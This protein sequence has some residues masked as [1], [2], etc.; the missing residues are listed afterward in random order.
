MNKYI[1]IVGILFGITLAG[2]QD[3]LEMNGADTQRD[4]DQGLPITFTTE[5]L[6]IEISG[7]TLTRAT[8]EDKYK[9]EFIEAYEEE[10]G[11]G[12]TVTKGD[13]LH[14]SATFTLL[15]ED[16]Q[17]ADINA[18]TT[19]LYDCMKLQNGEWTSMGGGLTWPWNAEK[20]TFTVYYINGSDGLL[21]ENDPSEDFELSN[22]TYDTDPLMAVA[23]DVPYGYAVPLKFNHLC[24][25]LSITDV[26]DRGSE[27]WAKITRADGTRMANQFSLTRNEND[28]LTF[29][30]KTKDADENP[31]VSAQRT[32]ENYVSYYLAPGDYEGMK[33]TYRYDRPYL[34]LNLDELNNLKK[35]HSYVVS[36]TD[37]QGSISIDE[38]EDDWWEEPGENVDEVELKELDINAFLKAI[39]DGTA[40]SYDGTPVLAAIEGGTELLVNIKFNSETFDDHDLPNTVF[41]GNYHYIRCVKRPLFNLINGGRIQN[42]SVYNVEIEAEKVTSVGAIARE[43]T[44]EGEAIRNVRLHGISIE[45]TPTENYNQACDV[46]ALIGVSNS[47]MSDIY[48]GGEISVKAYTIDIE[49]QLGTINV[50][51]LIGQLN[52]SGQLNNVSH[53]EEE[54]PGCI[55][56]NS[57][58][59]NK[60]GDRNTGG[61][62]GLSN[63]HVADCVLNNATVDA[64]QTRGIMVYTGGLVGMAR[65]TVGTHA[66]TINANGIFNSTYS[67]IIKCGRAYSTDAEGEES[68]EGHAYAG[69]AVGYAYWSD[70]IEGNEIF[71]TII[72][73]IGDK[74]QDFTPWENSIYATGGLFGQAYNAPTSGNTTWISFENVG[75]NDD[76]KEFYVGKIAGRADES[77]SVTSNTSHVTG[78]WKDIGAT[79]TSIQ[80]E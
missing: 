38:D 76:E 4:P 39:C 73:P 70:K 41:D 66:T 49:R 14:V 8:V 45:V 9:T 55:T 12:H 28:E 34:T 52:A 32:E 56:V 54:T 58:C 26:S 75:S 80:G 13:F 65:G 37:N 5:I 61:L 78:N 11:E 59:T 25:K 27:Y 47:T 19:T 15:N 20:G 69:G 51:G 63:G 46:G 68:V 22:V 42:L 44:Q 16:G 10:D 53:L 74:D 21:L 43:S 1:A 18:E 6:P 31:Y 17:S 23:E 30:F 36:I 57:S 62:V 33:L 3:E 64:S 29:A 60:L 7:S 71:G 77:S 48:L 24:T 2:C 79:V 50:G 67:G 40:Y 72:G 35:G